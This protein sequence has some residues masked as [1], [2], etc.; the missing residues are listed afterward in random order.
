M[1]APEQA[2]GYA[3]S[4]SLFAAIVILLC[5]IVC[6]D[7]MN[8]FVRLL[9]ER[10]S[11]VELTAYRNTIGVIPSLLYLWWA[12]EL[13]GGV[14]RLKL[15]QWPLGLSRGVMVAIAQLC[16]YLALSH[17]EFATA[18]ALVYTLS[19]FTVALSIPILGERV[20]P[21]RWGSVVLGFL[22]AML[23][24]RPGTQAF[25]PYAA[26]PLIAAFFYALSIVT[27]RRIDVEVSSAVIYLYSSVASAVCMVSYAILSGAFS[28]IAL[29]GDLIMIAAMGLC[30]GTGVL[31][32][33]I[34]V[35][36]ASPSVLA[37]FN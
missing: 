23:I 24:L 37:P 17:M 13:Q 32:L 8:V 10:Y 19:L 5:G 15:R 25:E 29:N 7:S 33:L 22:G 30:G 1:S 11:T 27:A 21:W 14:E 35:R 9:L 26:F 28:P 36:K 16:Y 34:A 3:P 6:L 2:E 31:L 20:G 4:S 12:G 18:A